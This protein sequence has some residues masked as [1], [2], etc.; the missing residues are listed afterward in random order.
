ML[1]RHLSC[2]HAPGIRRGEGGS[3]I[4]IA[5]VMLMMLTLIGTSA[6]N[7]ATIEIQVAGNERTYK[8]NFYQAESAAM[9]AMADL[10]SMATA[11]IKLDN[12][13]V[14]KGESFLHTASDTTNFDTLSNW[15]AV[16]STDTYYLQ[17]N[18]GTDDLDMTAA[19]RVYKYVAYGLARQNNATRAI[20]QVGYKRRY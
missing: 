9:R 8:Q 12:G 7:T 5:L 17:V 1:G 13:G 11:T 3:I 16:G 6:T 20:I 18:Q 2:F 10:Q 19:S 15:Q 4:V 14:I